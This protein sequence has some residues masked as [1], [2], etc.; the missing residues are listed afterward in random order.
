M[1]YL[2]IMALSL[3]AT[4]PAGAQ[5]FESDQAVFCQSVGE[6]VGDIQYGRA[7]GVEDANN[8][9][10]QLIEALSEHAARPLM[11][12]ID[13]F[14]ASTS[15]LSS[16]WTEVIYTDACIYNYVDDYGRIKR[17]AHTLPV[18]CDIS[19]PDSVCLRNVV[20][21]IFENQII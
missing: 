20:T 4:L 9:A 15:P 6:A 13:Q 8:G 2:V 10:I 18:Q 19:E 3:A 14:I 11:P 16:S 21:F 5:Q 17:I 12:D 7:T 1:K